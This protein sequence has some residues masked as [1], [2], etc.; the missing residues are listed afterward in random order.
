MRCRPTRP[1][2]ATWSPAQSEEALP[3]LL[4]CVT[5]AT[6]LRLNL[7]LVLEAKRLGLPMVVALNMTDMAQEAGHRGR[8]R[9]CS[10]ASSACR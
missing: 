6:N 5:D 10:R 3:D 9:R 4:V 7:R 8:R 1:S 2:R